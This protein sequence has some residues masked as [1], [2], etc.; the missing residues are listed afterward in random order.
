MVHGLKSIMTSV[1]IRI[2]LQFDY[3]LVC[4]KFQTKLKIMRITENKQ[5]LKKNGIKSVRYINTFRTH[6]NTLIVRLTIVTGT[7]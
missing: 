7:R 6:F 1:N 4:F 3:F 5:S 2:V